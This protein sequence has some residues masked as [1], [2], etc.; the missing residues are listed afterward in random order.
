M[1]RAY[2]NKTDLWRNGA[3]ACIPSQ[4]FLA[5]IRDGTRNARLSGAMSIYILFLINMTKMRRAIRDLKE[6]DIDTLCEIFRHPNP[7][8]FY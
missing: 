7:G 1:A 2:E 5:Y 3:N 4:T 8:S 6:D